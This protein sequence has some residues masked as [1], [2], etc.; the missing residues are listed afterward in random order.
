MS[1][2]SL[3]VSLLESEELSREKFRLCL[4]NLKDLQL[5]CAAIKQ[6]LSHN[7]HIFC[8]ISNRHNISHFDTGKK[9]NTNI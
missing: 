4:K 6:P 1:C 5:T 2:N 3:S 7:S 9:Q 8:K